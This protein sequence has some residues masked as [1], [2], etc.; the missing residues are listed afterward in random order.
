MLEALDC[1]VY[2]PRWLTALGAISAMRSIEAPLRYGHVYNVFH[3]GAGDDADAEPGE[4]TIA[5]T[6]LKRIV[7]SL[8][9]WGYSHMLFFVALL[10]LG[11]LLGLHG[12]PVLRHASSDVSVG[13]SHMWPGRGCVVRTW[14]GQFAPAHS[15]HSPHSP[16]GSYSLR[17]V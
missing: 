9:Y 17:A 16:R 15:L 3:A 1:C 8:L 4:H 11:F 6:V 12:S 13:Y 2:D 10:L 5:G 14:A 7:Q